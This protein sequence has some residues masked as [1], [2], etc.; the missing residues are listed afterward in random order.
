MSPVKIL[1]VDDNQDFLDSTRDYLEDLGN[2]EIVGTLTSGEKAIDII[3]K[4]LPDLI[5][6][7]LVM[8]GIDGLTTARVI[9]TSFPEVHIILLT[10]H[11]IDEYREAAREAGADAY[12]V[13]SEMFDT[14]PPL[15]EDIRQTVSEEVPMLNILI[16]D[17]SPTMR[18]MIKTS[19]GPLRAEFGE[20]SNG[21]EAIE[22]LSIQAYDLM[23]LDL[24]MPDM[25]GLEVA[26]FVRNIEAYR[27]LPILIISTRS[28]EDTQETAHEIGANSYLTKPFEPGELLAK[29]KEMLSS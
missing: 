28:D 2:I 3:Q 16:V 12:V 11:D 10:M 15:I 6:L 22:K 8:P 23:T 25:H 27:S 21:L 13:K 17:D 14:L 7:D 18:K 19:L 5:L 9:K 1:L 29:V 24:N 4:P 20:A 26:K